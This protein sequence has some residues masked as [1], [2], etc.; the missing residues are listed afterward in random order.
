MAANLTSTATGTFTTLNVTGD[1]AANT[2]AAI[3]RTS[4][5]GII[6]TGQG[7]T[8]DVT[9]KN[10]ADETVFSIP[11][12]TNRGVSQFTVA[13]W[14]NYKGTDTVALRDSFNISGVTDNGNG[15]Y[16]FAFSVNMNNEYYSVTGTANE[17]GSTGYKSVYIDRSAAP[18]VGAVRLQAINNSDSYS[19]PT[20]L[21]MSISG[22]TL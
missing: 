16:T 17:D 9:I 7:T 18:A 2:T 10:D 21:C 15:D 22:G 8:S 4:A 11:T 20:T 1:T 6:V 14:A 13:A 19:D 3:G 12:G 5:E